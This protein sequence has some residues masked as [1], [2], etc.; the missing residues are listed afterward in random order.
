MW[1]LAKQKDNLGL[2]HL[3]LLLWNR[4]GHFAEC[5][6]VIRICVYV[7]LWPPSVNSEV[8]PAAP[9]MPPTSTFRHSTMRKFR[10]RGPLTVYSWHSWSPVWGAKCDTDVPLSCTAI[11]PKTRGCSANWQTSQE[12]VNKTVFSPTCFSAASWVHFCVCG[13]VCVMLRVTTDPGAAEFISFF[14]PKEPYTGGAFGSGQSPWYWEALHTSAF[15]NNLFSHR[16]PMT[17]SNVRGCV[18]AE[19]SNSGLRRRGR[20]DQRAGRGV[21][22]LEKE[23]PVR[24]TRQRRVKARLDRWR[25]WR[26]WQSSHWQ[27]GGALDSPA[28]LPEIN[29]SSLSCWACHYD[30]VLALSQRQF[31]H[32]FL[33]SAD[34]SAQ[35]SLLFNH[36]QPANL[37]VWLFVCQLSHFGLLSPVSLQY[38][39]H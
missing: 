16:Q 29:L 1:Q 4:P 13:C 19:W 34:C 2:L 10:K 6:T 35:R 21:G 3:Q 25:G 17:G 22:K 5:N 23:K 36:V 30:V 24:Q 37:T 12:A 28:I 9:R 11:A 14:R 39:S 8:H 33:S 15:V 32:C 27:R 26:S 7:A 18:W 31:V 20:D 38:K